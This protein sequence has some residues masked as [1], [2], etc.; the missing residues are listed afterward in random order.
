MILAGSTSCP[1]YIVEDL[2]KSKKCNPFLKDK[3]G[4]TA[5]HWAAYHNNASSVDAILESVPE[6]KKDLLNIKGK[7]GLTAEE[8]AK[9]ENNIQVIET[10]K[11]SLDW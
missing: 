5:L 4:W 6:K 1:C 8:V 10:I 2:A 3:D 11:T 9:K 7:D